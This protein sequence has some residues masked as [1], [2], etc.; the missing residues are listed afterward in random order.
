[1]PSG[2][3]LSSTSGAICWSIDGSNNKPGFGLSDFI[4]EIISMISS[5]STPHNFFKLFKSCFASWSKFSKS[6]CIAGSNRFLSRNCRAKHSDK[7]LANTPG[8][9]KCCNLSKTSFTCSSV[10]SRFSITSDGSVDK[11]PV[12]SIISIR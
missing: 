10:Q 4:S 2:L 7:S 9:S 8:G 1:M 11:Y 5:S 3:A 12:S 6:F